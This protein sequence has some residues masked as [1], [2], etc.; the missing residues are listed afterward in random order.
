M[1]GAKVGAL[2]LEERQ[3]GLGWN[4][5]RGGGWVSGWGS[6]TAHL[7]DGSKPGV[8]GGVYAVD[9]RKAVLQRRSKKRDE[10][11]QSKAGERV[12]ALAEPGG[13]AFL[14]RRR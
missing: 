12:M 5:W 7:Q 4:R 2:A 10:G 11:E 6:F 8:V 3:V 9:S 14:R 13:C 1:P